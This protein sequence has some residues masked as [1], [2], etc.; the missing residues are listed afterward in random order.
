MPVLVGLG[1][2]RT[3]FG[4]QRLD[5]FDAY[6]DLGEFTLGDGQLVAHS[7]KFLT[8]RVATAHRAL[9]VFGIQ[10]SLGVAYGYL[11]RVGAPGDTCLASEGAK[12]AVNLPQQIV[13]SAQVRFGIGQLA[14]RAFLALAVFQDAGGLFD[15]RTV[16][17]RV[18]LQ[19]R[20]QSSLTHNHVHLLAKTGIGEEFLNVEQ[21]ALRAVD[22]VFGAAVAED[23]AGYGDFRVID[24]ERV[25]GIIDGQAHLCT[26]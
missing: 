9:S 24:I 23:G 15:E 13:K 20:I 5:L 1:D 8:Y 6:F 26:A 19:N 4:A 2:G 25:I 12:L 16:T 7:A 3:G 11:N 17:G 21:T 22:R 10:T 18:G 14:Q